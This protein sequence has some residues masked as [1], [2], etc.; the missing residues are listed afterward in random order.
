MAPNQGVPPPSAVLHVLP[1]S[2]FRVGQFGAL[3]ARTV[4]DGDTERWVLSSVED[5]AIVVIEESDDMEA[6][7]PSVTRLR[8]TRHHR[9][10]RGEVR[11]VF[12]EML[13]Q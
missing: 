5:G 8:V 2:K 1:D 10:K 7:P 6:L 4:W 12:A 13:D 9:K 11:G 3:I